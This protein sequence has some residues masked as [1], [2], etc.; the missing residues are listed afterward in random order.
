MNFSSPPHP[1]PLTHSHTHTHTHT[2]THKTQIKSEFRRNGSN[3]PRIYA[4]KFAKSRHSPPK[5][6]KFPS[7]PQKN[8]TKES[9]NTSDESPAR[10]P[11]ADPDREILDKLKDPLFLS[12]DRASYPL[13]MFDR[14][15]ESDLNDFKTTLG[16]K[17][18]TRRYTSNG[19]YE[20][21]SCEVAS[22]DSE[23]KRFEIRVG[24]CFVYK[25]IVV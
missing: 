8:E 7:L 15:I 22:Y 16:T 6:A 13:E 23:S 25:R 19:T 11:A 12:L 1:L 18:R 17:A 5:R 21:C 20:W 10:I 3:I 14:T 9:K 4:E 2:H 24:C